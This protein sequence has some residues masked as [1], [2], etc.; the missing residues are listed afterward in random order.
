M[1]MG[2]LQSAD[3][4]SD[5]GT[6]AKS[7]HRSIYSM[8]DSALSKKAL[9]ERNQWKRDKKCSRITAARDRTVVIQTALRNTVASAVHD[10]GRRDTQL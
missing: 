3:L 8:E 1:C 4:V 5:P 9:L 6:N 10:Q 7:L 2:K